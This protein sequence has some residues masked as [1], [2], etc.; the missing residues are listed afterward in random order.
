MARKASSTDIDP[1]RFEQ[2]QRALNHTFAE[3]GL[4]VDAL[5]HRSYLN[6]HGG[7]GVVSNERLEFLGD[8][9]LALVSAE[10]LYRQFPH[11]PEGELTQLRAA[12]VRGTA[13]AGFAR[14][15][16]L[17]EAVRVARSEEQKSG[18]ERDAL[19]AATFEAVLGAL[20]LDA[21]LEE[22]RRFLT[23]LLT[24]EAEGAIQQR[25]VKDAK[26]RLQELAQA[27]LGVT[28]RYRTV[29]ESGPAHQRTFT[30]EV[31]IGEL[32]PARGEGP[33]KQQA[34]QAAARLALQDQGWLDDE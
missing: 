20:Y 12:L 33:S 15:Y 23:P 5:T 19:L 3:P 14:R 22:A 24:E 30:V 4:L 29:S 6:E 26:S 34:E 16:A 13:L 18:R 21:G 28:P 8:A 25:R 7:P 9:V 11:A 2:L 17:G 27:R 32:A 31:V 10:L 1:E